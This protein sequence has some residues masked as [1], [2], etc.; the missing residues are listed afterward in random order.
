V[1]SGSGSSNNDSGSS[2]S[3][4]GIKVASAVCD[5]DRTKE[6]YKYTNEIRDEVNC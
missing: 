4:D 2:S 1:V 3:G 5:Y 6:H